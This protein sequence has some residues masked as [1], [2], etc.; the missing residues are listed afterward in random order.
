[1]RRACAWH[2]VYAQAH[3]STRRLRAKMASTTRAQ[4][5]DIWLTAHM[6]HGSTAVRPRI[7]THKTDE[8][9]CGAGTRYW[10]RSAQFIDSSSR[11]ITLGVWRGC[12]RPSETAVTGRSRIPPDC[13]LEPGDTLSP[14]PQLALPLAFACPPF[15]L[16][17]HARTRMWGAHGRA[18]AAWR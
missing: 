3:A 5:G 7:L 8:S 18:P 12:L 4:T 14:C 16:H 17:G 1:M 13:S 2:T 11:F 9:F 6:Q 10:S 15:D